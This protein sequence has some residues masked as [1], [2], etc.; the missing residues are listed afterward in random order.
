MK[1]PRATLDTFFAPRSV[2]LIGATE[3]PGSVGCTILWNLIQSPFGGTVYPVNTKRTS[4]LGIRAYPS[5]TDV[6][7]KVGLA[8]VVTPASTVPGVIRECAGAGVQGAIIISAGFK[9]AG[10]QG[11]ELERQRR[12]PKHASARCD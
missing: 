6:S 5:I 11:L 4:V 2:A 12:W 3:K 8:I 1:T 9:E 7:E 10:P